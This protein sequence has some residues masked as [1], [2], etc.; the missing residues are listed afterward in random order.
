MAKIRIQGSLDASIA[1]PPSGKA[2]IF[3]NHIEK[4]V[5]ARLDDGSYVLLTVSEEYVQDVVGSFF[6]DSSTIDV[7]YNDAGNIIGINVIQSALDISQIPNVPSG[8]LAATT[9]QGALNELQGDIDNILLNAVEAAQDAIGSAIAAGTQDGITVTYNDVANSISFENTDKGSD[10]IT[11]HEAALDPHPQ[12][13]TATEVQAK[14]DLHANLTNNPH[15]V[16]KAQVGLGLAD[17]TSD[18]DKPVSTAQATAIGVVNTALTNH[19]ADTAD[20]H[21]ASAISVVPTGNIASTDVQ[22]ALVELQG[23]INSISSNFAEDAQDAVGTIL[24]DSADIQFSY[25]DVVPDI[26]AVL[27]NTTVTSGSYG[28]ASN[29]S[30]IAVDSKGRIT[31]ATD[32]PIAIPSTQITDFTEAAQDAVASALTD[33][34]SVDLAYNDVSNTI[35]ATVLPAGV[36]HN[37]LQN[38]VANKHIDHSLVNINAGTGLTGGGNITADRTISMPNV[39]TAGTYGSASQTPI[40]ITD[41]QGRVSS[42]ISTAITGVPAANITNTPAGTVAA[43]TVQAA[44]N[45]LDSE[46]QALSEKGQANGYVPLGADSKIATSFL[47]DTVLGSVDYKGVWDANTN[48]PD[49]TLISPT[50]GDYYVVSVSG[51]TSLDGI[52]DWMIGDWAIFNGTD[53]DKVDNTDQVVS[54]FG[55]QGAVSALSGD[56]T[57]SQIANVA[58]GNIASTN[59]Q[60]AINELDTEKAAKTTTITAGTGLSGGGDLSANRTISMPN[61]GTSGIYGSASQVPV[62]TT[63]AQGR[64]SSI[65]NAP[66]SITSS[67]VTDFTEAAQDAIGT[68][69]AA[70]TQDGITATYSDVG[71]SVSFTNTDK[72]SSAVT[73]HEAALDPHGQYLKESDNILIN[74]QVVRVKISNAGVGEFTDLAL[75]VAS[76][77]DSDP[78]TKPYV[79]EMGAGNFLVNNPIILPAGVSVRGEGI[80]TTSVS[81]VDPNEHL[82]MLGTLSE[83]SFLN[84]VGDAGSVGSGKAAIYAEDVGEFGQV[85]KVSIYDFDIP[86]DNYSNLGT[87]IVYVEYVDVNGAFSFGARN[88]ANSGTVNRL[89]LE[90]FYTY[91]TTASGVCI[92]STGVTAELLLNSSGLFGA[93][94]ISGIVVS[95][96]TRLSSSDT[97]IKDFTGT[98]KGLAIENVGAG[99]VIDLSGVICTNNNIDLSVENPSTSGV[100]NITADKTK[101][102]IDDLADVTVLI[103]DS[104]VGG[105]S[106]TGELNYSSSTFSNIT[107]I[108]PL[109]LTSSTMGVFDG[110]ELSA[111]AGLTLNVAALKGYISVGVPPADNVE[112]FQLAAQTI[113]ITAS[114]NNYIYINSSAILVQNPAAPDTTANILLGRVVTNATDIIFIEK[115]PLDSH[116]YSNKIDRVFREAIG[117]VYAFGSLVSENGTRGL[118]V[119]A[120]EYYYSETEF[121]PV[122]GTGIS[123]SSFYESATAGVYTRVTGVTTVDRDFYDDGTGTL[124]SIPSGKHVK[125]LLMVLGGPS[126]QYSLIYATDYYNTLAEAQAAP[127]PIV[128]NFMSGAFARV[129]SVIVGPAHTNILDIIDERPRVGFASSSSVGGITDH[130]ALSGLGDNDHDQYL[131]RS[132]LNIMSGN[133]DMGGN[134]ISNVDLVDGIN[135][136]AHASRHAFNGADPFLSAA[137]QTVGTANAEGVSNTQFSRADHVHAHGNQTSPTQHAVAT[138]SANGFMSS[139]D[140]TKLDGISGTRIFKA[141]GIAGAS[142][143]GAPR[144]ATVTFGTAFPNTNYSIHITGANSRSWSWES[145]TVNG[146]VIN[147]NANAALSGE[148]T[149]TCTSY[150]E[151]VE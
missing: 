118:N 106:F 119:T 69:I 96:G 135:V 93:D 145:K 94:S 68:A 44:I 103:T 21:D 84:L 19:I 77:T 144:K 74:P 9:V 12:Y 51:A 140:K 31:S 56:Y 70:G 66:I 149:W 39:G 49:L 82:F 76:I 102:V 10:A 23:D 36:D 104:A 134:S 32:T 133:L 2:S 15:S 92:S 110:G 87:S 109:V 105:V 112:Y 91:P 8:N 1:I 72:G 27:T 41:A 62:I 99:P 52:T 121:E 131:L 4:V 78:A 137:P 86:I 64:A 57:A 18:M 142:F 98:G 101:C 107:D 48:T 43:T 113:S 65:T 128:P 148:V 28:T 143:T 6:Q 89:F 5:K 122:G 55:R 73:A 33:S 117:S 7:V 71:N 114:S 127:L 46:K 3:Y 126:E 11:S 85:H 53:W 116:H 26:S 100:I 47:P 30:T 138:T 75:A 123:W 17:N 29:V 146:F 129:A 37:S 83:I 50:K 45:E 40:L 95:D 79:I 115:S 147:A 130:G 80:N 61:V 16:T 24:S 90:N 25:N 151:T 59:V 54:V 111:G 120:G 63:D 136:T 97:F 13:E 141:G 34:S 81:P 42:V 139:T 22:S 60:T 38:F 58:S 124:A 20:A 14:V 125:H 132:G 67:A 88:R 108:G 35:T 150:G